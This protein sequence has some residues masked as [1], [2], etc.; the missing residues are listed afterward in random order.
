MG[1]REVLHLL[2]DLEGSVCCQYQAPG[3]GRGGGRGGDTDGRGEEESGGDGGGDI[4]PPR[5]RNLALAC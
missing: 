1:T 3:G 5:A 2:V 4:Q